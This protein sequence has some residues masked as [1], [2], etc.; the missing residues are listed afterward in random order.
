[1]VITID[2]LQWGDLDS[3][4]FMKRLLVTPT[5]P[6]LLLIA[7]YR[8]EDIDTS[9]FLQSWRASLGM[10][11]KL[12]IH[13]VALH[14]LT[15]SESKEL[16]VRLLSVAS[17]PADQR[18]EAIAMESQGSPFLIDRFARHGHLEADHI[19]LATVSQIL[20]DQ[21]TVLPSGIRQLLELIAVA[22]QPIACG[23]ANAAVGLQRDSQWELAHLV[24]ERFVRIRDTRGPIQVE[25]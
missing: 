14:P 17:V 10:A 8:S 7:N 20:G 1:M 16:A 19:G 18:A 13:E 9:P 11:T 25:P 6:S 12:D 5:P 24:A 15:V 21:L 3:A 4:A 23:T 22:G 2:D